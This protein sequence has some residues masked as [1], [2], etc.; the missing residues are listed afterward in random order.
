MLGSIYVGRK[1]VIN[2]SI[3]VGNQN[4]I[5]DNRY[6]G[7]NEIVEIDDRM[8]LDIEAKAKEGIL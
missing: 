3:L 1:C 2:K 8:R 5:E 6:V 7:P 4:Y